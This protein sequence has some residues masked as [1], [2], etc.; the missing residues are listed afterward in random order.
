MHDVFVSYSSLDQQF[1][2][3]LATD[4]MERG[5]NVWFAD[6]EMR[7][8]ESLLDRISSAIRDSSYLFVVIS[9]NSVNS[10]WVRQELRQAM[11]EEIE[12]SQMKVVPILRQQCELP[13]FLTDKIYVDLTDEE[14]YEYGVQRLTDL[15]F[16]SS[17]AVTAE[18]P[19]L[20]KKLLAEY[21]DLISSDHPDARLFRKTANR[22]YD[23][24]DKITL[25]PLHEP[26]R[27]ISLKQKMGEVALANGELPKALEAFTSAQRVALET[28]SSDSG[29]RLSATKAC[30]EAF[31]G[32]K[33]LAVETFKECLTEVAEQISE[34]E[35][36]N[37]AAFVEHAIAV[38]FLEICQV[39]NPLRLAYRSD[40]HILNLRL[41]QALDALIDSIGSNSDNVN[42]EAERLVLYGDLLA[43]LGVLR[44]AL[45]YY[46][47]ASKLGHQGAQAKVEDLTS[48]QE[49]AMWMAKY[50]SGETIE[51]VPGDGLT[52]SSPESWHRILTCA[53]VA[54]QIDL[55]PEIFNRK[56]TEDAVD[57][58]RTN[59]IE[60]VRV[61]VFEDV[62]N[63]SD[64]IISELAKLGIGV[65]V[66]GDNRTGERVLADCKTL[67]MSISDHHQEP[68]SGLISI[69][70]LLFQRDVVQ[71]LYP[72]VATVLL[73]DDLESR[74]AQGFRS[75]G[76]KHV[77]KASRARSAAVAQSI[78]TLLD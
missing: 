78:R 26:D 19:I 17:A 33:D 6:W 31:L 15:V 23:L 46:R 49:A 7:P 1:V 75:A 12:S 9:P 25:S 55:S 53:G 52:I 66:V 24:L 41:Q 69:T 71:K 28:R 42:D 60:P 65:I 43:G 44:P 8:G 47:K 67:S 21:D 63:S 10:K 5:L 16:D 64:M 59:G 68:P 62:K 72:H 76:G 13:S 14:W 54:E 56:A 3:R 58:V 61:L 50:L 57:D 18:R 30:I 45:K 38:C 35:S 27:F 4:L 74:T 73:C 32:Q 29:F 34:D 22:V 20:G 39:K 2:K 37:L 77:I 48:Q 11:S 40:P 36:I 51:T 70:G